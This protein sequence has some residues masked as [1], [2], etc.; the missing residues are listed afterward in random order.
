MFST[1]GSGSMCPASLVHKSL[2]NSYLFILKSTQMYFH[3][4][5]ITIRKQKTKNSN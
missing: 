4:K 1:L 3:R 5:K 2:Y